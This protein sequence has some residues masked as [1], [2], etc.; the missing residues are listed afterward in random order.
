MID[1]FN[2]INDFLSLN[3]FNHKK[4][5]DLILVLGNA[6]PYV[7]VE[8][9]KYY[10]NG[11]SKYFMISGGIGHTTG[12]MKSK[13]SEDFIL[14][15]QDEA[16]ILRGLIE[17]IYD[18]DET[19]IIENESTNCGMNIHNSLDII[20]KKKLSIKSILLV[21][22]PLMQR[23]IDATAKKQSNHYEFYNLSLFVPNI[24]FKCGYYV[25]NDFKGLWTF[26][27]YV[28]LMLGEMKRLIDN[29]EGYGPNGMN[30]ICHVDIP[31]EVECSYNILLNKYK[32]QIRN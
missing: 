25:S 3:T 26:D 20:C 6:L 13:I 14:S 18:K 7:A 10:K 15:Y 11:Y 8:A 21:H 17:H 16:S 24:K 9:Y 23:R 28:S 12:A 27:E 32:N 1:H 22:D 30:Y 4:K 31:K 19:I 5:Y 2:K 29:C